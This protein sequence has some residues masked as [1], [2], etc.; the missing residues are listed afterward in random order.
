MT[1]DESPT[2][3][4][5]FASG[6]QVTLGEL[7]T[8]G[9]T[10]GNRVVIPTERVS[11]RHAVIRRGAD[12]S[13]EL[14]DMGSSNGTWV[15]GL[16]L[17]RPMTLANAMVIEIGLVKMTF[18]FTRSPAA[19]DRAGAPLIASCW[20]L[21]L[22]ATMRGCREPSQGEGHKTFEGWSERC[23]RIVKKY[24]GVSVRALQDGFVAFWREDAVM[25]K[26]ATIATV[27]RSLRA[28]QTLTEEFRFAMHFGAVEI[29]VG[30][31]GESRP[32]GAEFV[33][34]LQLQ[35]LVR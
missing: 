12:G 10:P 14:M 6:E 18:R 24:Q 19:A 2:A 5:E 33:S 20:L 7:C 31:S 23:Q 34:I 21:A 4:L 26:A 17:V 3:W 30:V 32:A 22:E 1:P 11:R 16:R 29:R 15:N 8:I 35:K 25:E 27:L 13:F 28:V 9:R